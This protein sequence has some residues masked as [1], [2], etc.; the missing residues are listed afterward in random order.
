MA[1][2]KVCQPFSWL[3]ALFR[4]YLW[5]GIVLY[6]RPAISSRSP[7]SRNGQYSTPIPA[8]IS[9]RNADLTPR[10]S[11]IALTNAC[12]RCATENP[13]DHSYCHQCGSRLGADARAAAPSSLPAFVRR[14]PDESRLPPPGSFRSGLY[15]L[16]RAIFVNQGPT[17]VSQGT[18]RVS[19]RSGLRAL[20]GRDRKLRSAALR[21][22]HREAPA[23]AVSAGDAAGGESQP[24]PAVAGSNADDAATT[25]RV[26]GAPHPRSALYGTAMYWLARALL[27]RHL[28]PGREDPPAHPAGESDGG[29]A[30]ERGVPT[31]LP[32]GLATTAPSVA[33]PPSGTTGS[34]HASASRGL[35]ARSPHTEGRRVPWHVSGRVIPRDFAERVA[36]ALGAASARAARVRVALVPSDGVAVPRYVEVAAVAALTVV[37]V[38]LRTWDLP[39]APRRCPPGRDRHGPGGIEVHR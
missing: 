34:P 17:T 15:R 2:R 32:G 1:I 29:P 25:I 13:P 35:A 14:P 4:Q 9:V 8:A 11:N 12:L 18:V 30:R 33:R 37:A 21:A 16:I 27:L 26:S 19:G 3:A 23:G 28:L 22:S 36:D 7:A 10:K 6:A 31:G 38:F 39:G 24:G 20:A 5:R